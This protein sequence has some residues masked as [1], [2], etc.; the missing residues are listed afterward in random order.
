MLLW[1]LTRFGYSKLHF[2]AI[3]FS[4]LHDILPFVM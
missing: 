3:V 4:F 2:A 1:F